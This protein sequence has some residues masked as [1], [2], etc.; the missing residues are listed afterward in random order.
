MKDFLLARAAGY[1]ERAAAASLQ[2][3]AATTDDLR[4]SYVA[5]SHGWAGLAESLEAAA[6]LPSEVLNLIK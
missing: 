5:L 3:E 1:R 2:A 4:L 6:E